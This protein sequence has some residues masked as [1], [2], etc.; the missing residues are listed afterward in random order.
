VSALARLARVVHPLAAAGVLV[1]I[2]VQVY[3]I[4]KFIFGDAHALSTHKSLGDLAPPV[5][6]L[7]FLTAAVGYWRNWRRIGVAALLLLT[8]FFQIS[9]AQNMGNS[10]STHALHGMLAIVVVVIAGQIARDGWRSAMGA[11]TTTA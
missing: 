8:G 2:A 3:L 7:V 4:S 10:P 9:F 5:E 1:V 11:R 6:F